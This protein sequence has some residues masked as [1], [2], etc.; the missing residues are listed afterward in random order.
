MRPFLIFLV[1]LCL[2]EAYVGVNCYNALKSP[3]ES[4]TYS[5]NRFSSLATNP[6]EPGIFE[7]AEVSDT[8]LCLCHAR[9][10][11]FITL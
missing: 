6:N 8:L 7:G 2:T 1:I 10:I 5:R 3:H 9:K 11:L 4:P